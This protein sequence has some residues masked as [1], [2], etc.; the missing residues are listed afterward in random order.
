MKFL[1]YKHAVLVVA[2]LGVPKVT[3]LKLKSSEERYNATFNAIVDLLSKFSPDDIYVSVTGDFEQFNLLKSE[4]N[5]LPDNNF[6]YFDQN[7]DK[8][9][10]GTSALEVDCILK[11]VHYF[12][13]SKHYDFVVKITGKHIVD[14]FDFLNVVNIKAQPIFA[15]RNFNKAQVDTRV[16]IFN[17]SWFVLSFRYFDI[18]SNHTGNYLE[19]VLYKVIKYQGYKSPLL[20]FRPIVS[21]LSGHSSIYVKM[22]CFK[23]FCIKFVSLPFKFFI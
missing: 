11:A 20:L 18:L 10:L 17:P 5:S 22:S 19:V 23:V 14:N 9:H 1:N 7:L 3:N 13:L 15:W 21:G 2:F 12:E 16:F 8:M 6:V 4:L